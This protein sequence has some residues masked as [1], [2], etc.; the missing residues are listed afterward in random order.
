MNGRAALVAGMGI[1]V[2]ALLLG[3]GRFARIEAADVVELPAPGTAVPVFLTDGTPVFVVR[4]SAGGLRAF[5]ARMPARTGVLR[6]MV[7]W[8]PDAG[9]FI[10]TARGAAYGTDG[11][12]RYRARL[13]G[14]AVRFETLQTTEALTRLAIERSATAVRIGAPLRPS[15]RGLDGGQRLPAALP[16]RARGGDRQE[17]PLHWLDTSRLVTHADLTVAPTPSLEEVAAAGATRLTP[18]SGNVV[19]VAGA[20][21]RA[22]SL[23][24]GDDPPRCHADAPAVRL[25]TPSLAGE[26]T[27]VSGRLLVSAADGA[28]TEVAA[29]PEAVIDGVGTSGAVQTEGDLVQYLG[30]AVDAVQVQLRGTD[31]ALFE[32]LTVC[33]LS[34]D[35][36]RALVPLARNPILVGGPGR[37]DEDARLTRADLARPQP[38][39]GDEPV[40][41]RL[42][43][44]RASCSL[45]RLVELS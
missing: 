13:L 25:A 12:P 8:C 20:V 21:A 37:G 42:T 1:A 31:P 9:V 40:P 6:R 26:F 18:T 17:P 39:L 27:H 28:I 22:C 3:G 10:D 5:D 43:I 45:V 2:V 36:G 15:G 11:R 19:A 23:V 32:L 16:C 41:V 29:L 38:L 34:G 7:G 30:P 24:S 44:D 33:R 4:D 14:R 35:G